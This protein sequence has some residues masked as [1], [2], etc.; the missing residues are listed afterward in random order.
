MERTL[1]LYIF[2]DKRSKDLVTTQGLIY[3]RILMLFCEC[4]GINFHMVSIVTVAAINTYSAYRTV[5]LS[6]S[7][8]Q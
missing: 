1:R 6:L 5:L 4:I 3:P 2:G 7:E 8:R